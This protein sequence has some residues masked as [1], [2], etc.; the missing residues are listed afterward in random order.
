MKRRRNARRSLRKRILILCEGETERNYFPAIKEDP[1]YKNRLSAV[2]A[3]VI[4]A[5]HPTPDHIV[6][7]ALKR[8]KKPSRPPTPMMKYGLSLTTTINPSGT[9]PTTTPMRP[10]SRWFFLPWRS[11]SGMCFILKKRP[12]F[13]VI[14]KTCS[15]H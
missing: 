6:S 7:E 11:K 8:R 14:R 13:S 1:T 4:K 9:K 2:S 3:Q 10:E 15:M 12:G 5:K